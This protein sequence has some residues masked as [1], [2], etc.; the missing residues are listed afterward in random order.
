LTPGDN[1]IPIR[2]AGD[3]SVTLLRRFTESRARE[4]DSLER[5]ADGVPLESDGE[6]KTSLLRVS[7]T[8]H[9]DGMI[10]DTKALQ[11]ESQTGLLLDD[12][13]IDF[14]RNLIVSD[15][16]GFPVLDR[17]LFADAKGAEPRLLRVIARRFRDEIRLIEALENMAF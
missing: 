8:F 5:D 15:L 4:A 14:E 9:P 17:T 16:E 2:G 6:A 11:L 13:A 3:L 7:E 10:T 1:S 12:G